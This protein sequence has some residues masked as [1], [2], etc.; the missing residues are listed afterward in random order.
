MDAFL[1][2]PRIASRVENLF[3]SS[4]LATLYM[5]GVTYLGLLAIPYIL[6]EREL[7][8]EYMEGLISPGKLHLLRRRTA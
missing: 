5:I 7:P 8:L 6:K 4:V 1:N 3:S 2:L